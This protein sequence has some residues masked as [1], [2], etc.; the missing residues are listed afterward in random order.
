MLQDDKML[1]SRSGPPL[2]AP[3]LALCLLRIQPLP[4]PCLAERDVCRCTR[5]DPS[6]FL[7]EA[8]NLEV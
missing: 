2:R 7:A 6:Q 5:R 8:L 3:L 1:N 4:W